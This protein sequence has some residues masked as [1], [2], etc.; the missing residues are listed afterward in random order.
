MTHIRHAF[1]L[2]RQSLFVV[3]TVG[4][5]FLVAGSAYA[6]GPPPGCVGGAAGPPS[7]GTV[8]PD[9]TF[10]LK[11]P[12]LPLGCPGSAQQGPIV[13]G[14][15]AFCPAR[16]G[17]AECIFSQASNTCNAP[18]AGASPIKTNAAGDCGDED[19]NCITADIQIG[20]NVLTIGVGVIITIM[21]IIGGLQYMLAR[22]NPQAVQ[23][24]KAKIINAIVAMISFMFVYAFLQWIVP[25]GIF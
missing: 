15:T 10:P 3:L 6:A 25:G 24:A 23:A 11:D 22:D 17:R 4:A 16:P 18:A 7:P 21:I 8:C 9:G 19:N 13:A 14:Y 12:S 1:Q 2:A 20:L 5:L